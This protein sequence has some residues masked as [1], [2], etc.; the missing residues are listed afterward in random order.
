MRSDW[1][2]QRI[3]AFNASLVSLF[4]EVWKARNN[5]RFNSRLVHWKI[6]V[7]SIALAINFGGNQ[8]SKVSNSSMDNF[9]IP[10]KL[11][12][13]IHPPKIKKTVNILWKPPNRGWIKCNVDDFAKGVPFSCSCGVIFINETVDLLGSFVNFLGDGNVLFAELSETMIVVEQAKEK[14]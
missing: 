5:I 7:A 6:C 11:K 3:V 4:A 14:M 13:S 2:P 8:T 1:F 12:I 10:K 9:C